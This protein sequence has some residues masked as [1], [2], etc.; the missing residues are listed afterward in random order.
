MGN[1][2]RSIERGVRRAVSNPVALFTGG[3]G[4]AP[5]ANAASGNRAAAFA[6]GGMLGGQAYLAAD[7]MG[8]Q[9]QPV[10][11]VGQAYAA[12]TRDA[13]ATY[14]Q[15]FMP[16]ENKLIEYAG[17]SSQPV[18]AMQ[19]ASTTVNRVFDRQQADSADRL[20]SMGLTLDADEQAAVDR[21]YGLARTLADVGAQNRARETTV[22]RQ[23][24]I[25]G[26]PNP[27]GGA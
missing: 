9:P 6:L 7:R 20:H 16:F 2:F 8:N 5:I 11:D 24:S 15:T 10:D 19:R 14:V 3:I 12:M 18:Q 1:P 27:L 22:A 17:D 4:G 13:W 26:N 21:G 25:L 23:R